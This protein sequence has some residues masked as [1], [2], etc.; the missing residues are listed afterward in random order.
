MNR[1]YETLTAHVDLQFAE[2][3]VLTLWKLNDDNV[4][5]EG[6]Q[7]A[8]TAQMDCSSSWDSAWILST[9]GVVP[10]RR[11]RSVRRDVGQTDDEIVR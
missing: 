2:I 5:S 10:Q 11:C 8:G 3:S 4:I 6:R 9:D 7:V 1:A